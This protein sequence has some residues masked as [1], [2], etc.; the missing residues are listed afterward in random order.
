MP[1]A[2]RRID[3]NESRPGRACLR[4]DDSADSKLQYNEISS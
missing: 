3:D 4:G 2:Q 1:Q